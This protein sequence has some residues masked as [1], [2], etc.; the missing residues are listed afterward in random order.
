MK[1]K[2][3]KPWN[4]G[5]K[6]PEISERMRKTNMGNQNAR[7]H[8]LPDKCKKTWFKK[9]TPKNLHP[10]WQGG[11][12]ALN[13]QIRNSERYV[14][15]RGKVLN[16]DNFTCQICKK[17]GGDLNIHHL[18]EF[19]KILKNNNIKSLQK[20]FICK[21]LWDVNNGITLCKKCHRKSHRLGLYNYKGVKK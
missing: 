15:W 17:V 21:K 10:R 4:K 1:N 7:G 6:M 19:S 9:G 5:K 2:T 13:I 8:K 20:A 16:R 14:D 18:E 12:T 11:I 3:K